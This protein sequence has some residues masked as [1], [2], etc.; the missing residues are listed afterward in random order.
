M[1]VQGLWS[2]PDGDLR[3]RPY[4]AAGSR[5]NEPCGQFGGLV[6]E[7]P[8]AKDDAG[9]FVEVV[10]NCTTFHNERR[11]IAYFG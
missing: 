9:E 2:P 4:C 11:I 8:S 6:P 5:G 3:D 7:L 10:Y 1:D